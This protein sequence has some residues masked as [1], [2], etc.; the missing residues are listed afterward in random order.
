MTAAYFGDGAT[1]ETDFHSGHELRR[2]VAHP[3]RVHLP[4]NLYAISVPYEKQTASPTIAEK[5]AAYGMPG[6]LVDGMDVLAVYAAS[7]EAVDRAAAGG[8]PTLIEAVATASAP[9]PPPT[10][11]ASTARLTRSGVAG[12][13]PGD[14]FTPYLR[15]RGQWDDDREA[16]LLAEAGTDFDRAMA[17]IE[18]R[19][20]PGRDDI[21]RH[22]AATVPGRLVEQLNGWRTC[23]ARS[24]RT[25]TTSPRRSAAETVARR[26]RRVVDHGRGDQRRHGRGDGAPSGDDP[27]AART[28][29]WPE[30][31]SAS[32]RASSSGSART[33]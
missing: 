8:G 26:P 25:S 29:G 14:R 16:A 4:N 1:S 3:H 17:E 19:P 9:T 33:G 10:T 5:A 23:A 7:R 27:A 31:C 20:L 32:P 28:W 13:G 18:S 30:G 24:R 2:G 11:P 22:A 21:I 12:A 6:V 15:G